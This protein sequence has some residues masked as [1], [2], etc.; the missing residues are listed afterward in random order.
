MA[1]TTTQSGAK[2][3]TLFEWEGKDKKGQKQKGLVSSPSADLVKAKLRRQGIVAPKVKKKRSG[4]GSKQKITPGD[5][6]IFARQLTT[7]MAPGYPWS[8][9]SRS[10]R[11]A[12]RTSPCARWSRGSRPKSSPAA[13]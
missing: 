7:M 12:W 6:A 5:I 11:T 9:P 2:P 4:G 1:T 13:T 8:S 3:T 10:S